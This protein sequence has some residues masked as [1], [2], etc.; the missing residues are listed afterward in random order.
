[1]ILSQKKG[2]ELWDGVH[3]SELGCVAHGRDM[4]K[5][6]YHVVHGT[7]S[8]GF[9][10]LEEASAMFKELSGELPFAYLSNN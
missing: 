1:M 3:P 10:T 8:E 7:E 2:I 6:F 9:D 4:C 5:C